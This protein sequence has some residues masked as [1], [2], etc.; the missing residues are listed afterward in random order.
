MRV[1][2]SHRPLLTYVICS[3][4]ASCCKPA[5]MRTCLMLLAICIS[6]NSYSQDRAE[7]AFR[8]NI[9]TDLGKEI[10]MPDPG[11]GSFNLEQF[12]TVKGSK[13]VMVIATD[14]F[15]RKIFSRYQS[16]S[17]PVIDF[18]IYDLVLF[19]ACGYFGFDC[20]SQR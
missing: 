9:P 3:I 16:D 6:F 14:S 20:I 1:T 17:I 18:R 19:S 11:M 4:A 13:N 5:I 15:Y 12:Q 2:D 7:I 8:A 10:K